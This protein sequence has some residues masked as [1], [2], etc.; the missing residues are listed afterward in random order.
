MVCRSLPQT[1]I[2]VPSSSLVCRSPSFSKATIVLTQWSAAG[3]FSALLS[4]VVSAR[5]KFPRLVAQLSKTAE[6]TGA[7]ASRAAGADSA[8]SRASRA[9]EILPSLGASGAIYAAV[10]LTAL[11]FPD[12]VVSL[13]FPPTWPIPIQLGVGA[14]VLVDVLGVIRGWRLVHLHSKL[15]RSPS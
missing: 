10:T 15:A 8:A 7:R 2:S 4:H 11:A 1:G 12:A 13:I 9:A 3:L 14:L 6:T 5:I